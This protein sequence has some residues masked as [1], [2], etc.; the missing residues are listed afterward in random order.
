M[1]VTEDPSGQQGTA[2]VAA[3]APPPSGPGAAQ[4]RGGSRQGRRDRERGK[5]GAKALI[6]AFTMQQRRNARQA[7]SPS[8]LPYHSLMTY[9]YSPRGDAVPPPQPEPDSAVSEST[10]N[11]VSL[12][13]RLPRGSR[14]SAQLERVRG[15]R[16]AA[17]ASSG[18][19]EERTR[20]ASAGPGDR[21]SAPQQPYDPEFDRGGRGPADEPVTGRGR[22]GR[23]RGAGKLFNPDLDFVPARRPSEGHE[24]RRGD[25]R[26]R[27]WPMDD[28]HAEDSDGPFYPHDPRFGHPPPP[29]PHHYHPGFGHPPPH[30]RGPFP[31]PPFHGQPPGPYGPPPPFG[32]AFNRPEHHQFLGPQGSH[33]HE[34]YSGQQRPFDAPYPRPHSPAAR[35]SPGAG[36]INGSSAAGKQLYD[37]RRD[38]PVRF[39][40]SKRGNADS[41]S[42]ASGSVVSK[43]K[44]KEKEAGSSSGKSK[45][46]KGSKTTGAQNDLPAPGEEESRQSDGSNSYVK[47]LKSAYKVIADLEKALKDEESSMRA[48]DEELKL[49]DRDTGRI[50]PTTGGG[51]MRLVGHKRSTDDYW[52]KLAKQHQQLAEAHRHF[53]DMALDP[54]LPESLHSLPQKYNI[55]V[56]LWQTAFHQ[57]LER[58]RHALPAISG[59]TAERNAESSSLIEHMVDFIYYAY[60]FYTGLLGEPSFV[61]FRS[62]WI[63]Q[64]GDLAR[65]RMAVASLSAKYSAK[66]PTSGRRTL[67]EAGSE[68]DE[69]DKDDD[70]AA[71]DGSSDS[72]VAHVKRTMRK[73]EAG[74]RID[75]E[76]K[77][78]DGGSIG[79]AALNDW[80][81]EEQETWRNTARDWYAKGLAE[82]PAVGRLHHH[83]AL[84]SKGDEL[85]ALYHYVKRYDHL[86]F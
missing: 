45:S 18:P 73:D 32:Q 56:R 61:V 7:R 22:G 39:A 49:R 71:R 16:A 46:S 35:D 81:Y 63:E 15:A 48:R 5:D 19:S 6:D 3:D 64:L 31:P 86:P 47:K 72:Y 4:Q 20:G 83:L 52:V 57:L 38:D 66:G 10:R 42:A 59:Q 74:G 62:A 55:P 13:P 70:A 77:T 54:R 27:A 9:R 29:P 43:G 65:Y 58:L 68:D 75:E 82:T 34:H 2:T 1:A 69:D 28:R 12:P 30:H 50:V 80:E 51:D 33:P 23:G 26:R 60:G 17:N 44:K 21:V 25:D 36:S 79:V 41:K 76:A 67:S 8:Y 85:R 78:R 14:A 40:S 37:P 24:S 11:Q 53:L 84:L